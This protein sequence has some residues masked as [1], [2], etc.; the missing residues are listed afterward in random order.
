MGSK[1][2]FNELQGRNLSR[3]DVLQ[4][5]GMATVASGPWRLGVEARAGQKPPPANK[6][7]LA[8]DRVGKEAALH[9]G[10]GRADVESA[11]PRIPTLLCGVK[12][13]RNRFQ[14]G[15]LAAATF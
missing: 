1:D 3:R 4:L 6:K 7:T 12:G 15:K 8:E 5:L 2:L 13:G 9:S 11:T 10:R 14:L